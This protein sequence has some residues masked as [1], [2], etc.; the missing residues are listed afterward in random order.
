MNIVILAFG[1]ISST[2]PHNILIEEYRKRLPWKL[3][4]IELQE[5]RSED[6]RQNSQIILQN[7]PKGYSL[8]VLDE[9]GTNLTS[10]QFANFFSESQLLRT[11]N[12]AFAI[13]GAYGH[14]ESLLRSAHKVI[15]FGKQ[16]L[17]HKFVRVMLTEQIYRAYTILHNHPYN[18]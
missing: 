9:K 17:P 16:T 12:L 1:K 7:L 3:Q 14:D 4:I 2:D 11:V 10:Q 18:K 8:V 15:S 6:K 13:G 5:K